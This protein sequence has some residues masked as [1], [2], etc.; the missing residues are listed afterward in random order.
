MYFTYLFYLFIINKGI[1]KKLKRSLNKTYPYCKKLFNNYFQFHEREREQQNQHTKF[2]L[3]VCLP[4][5]NIAIVVALF[6]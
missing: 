6:L 4:I 3:L 2:I 5:E 1:L